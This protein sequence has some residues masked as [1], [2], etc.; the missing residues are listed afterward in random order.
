MCGRKLDMAIDFNAKSFLK[1]LQCI[2]L[3]SSNYVTIKVSH[4]SELQ[5][6]V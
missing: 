1:D 2:R 3:N 4:R 6:I 5:Q